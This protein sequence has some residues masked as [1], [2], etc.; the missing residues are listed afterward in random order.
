MKLIQDAARA[1]HTITGYGADHVA[2]DKLPHR[3]SL[4]VLPTQLV[5][6]WDARFEHLEPGDFAPLIAL[7][8]EVVLL[9][10][11]ARQ[12]FPRP[13]VLRALIEAGIGVE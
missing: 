11:G 4:I 7:R 1:Q 8:P 10:T 6:P 2:I 9:G 13:D 5:S 3:N 12:R